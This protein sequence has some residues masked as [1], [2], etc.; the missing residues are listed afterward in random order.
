MSFSL[1]QEEFLG[2]IMPL[3]IFHPHALTSLVV[4]LTSQE[5]RDL[6]WS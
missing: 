4:T 1:V 5:K 2:L 3:K 6:V